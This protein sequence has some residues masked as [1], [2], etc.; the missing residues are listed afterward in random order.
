V[1]GLD[2]RGESAIHCAGR[3]LQEEEAPFGEPA[4][5]TRTDVAGERNAGQG[6][7]Q[8]DGEQQ[9]ACQK[10]AFRG[11]KSADSQHQP[12]LELH[13]LNEQRGKRADRTL[14]RHEN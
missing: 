13:R 2:V 11:G 10:E 4:R 7:Q 14:S 1:L 9:E 5:R 12:N 8:L 6:Q 3:P